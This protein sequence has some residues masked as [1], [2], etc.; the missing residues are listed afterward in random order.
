MM[1]KHPAQSTPNRHKAPAHP[2]SP[3]QG[4]RPD[5]KSG[6]GATWW[7]S[8]EL[9][10]RLPAVLDFRETAWGREALQGVWEESRPRLLGGHLVSW[11]DMGHWHWVR[12]TVMPYISCI[13]SGILLSH[14]KER[15][16]AIGS[17]M[18]GRRDY[19]IK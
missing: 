3:S 8:L 14:K 13:S 12:V 10:I 1:L 4:R 7:P 2:L 6:N 15:N 16:I 5:P 17:N 9:P 11:K 18:G 19:H